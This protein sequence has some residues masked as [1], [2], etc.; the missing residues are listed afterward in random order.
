MYIHFPS[1]IF[2]E[3]HDSGSVVLNHR[4]IKQQRRTTIINCS[5]FVIICNLL[6]AKKQNNGLLRVCF[7]S[8]SYELRNRKKI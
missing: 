6:T 5:V 7:P 8:G 2:K 1:S 4:L 3:Q